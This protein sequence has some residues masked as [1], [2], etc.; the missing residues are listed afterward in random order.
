MVCL[1]RA[2]TDVCS[3]D[4]KAAAVAAVAAEVA[5]ARGD[6]GRGP[7]PPPGAAH[8]RAVYE[9]GTM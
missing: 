3:P 5:A 2:A 6:Q 8:D 9:A 7:V 1:P 4:S